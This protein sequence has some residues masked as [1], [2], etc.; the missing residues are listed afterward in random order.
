VVG[1]V[2]GDC[3]W[4]PRVTVPLPPPVPFRLLFAGCLTALPVPWLPQ[5][6][7]VRDLSEVF[8]PVRLAWSKVMCQVDPER[9]RRTSL[10]G[11]HGRRT[12][13]GSRRRVGH[14]VPSRGPGLNTE[15]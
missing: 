2:P 9:W 5:H 14:R 11:S 1:V 7:G 6:A 12:Q 3:R 4:L 8:E 10:Q 13:A 15:T